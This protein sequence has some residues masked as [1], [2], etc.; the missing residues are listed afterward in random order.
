MSQRT[1]DDAFM[2]AIVESSDDAIVSKDL[3]GIV[4]SWNPAAERIFG[5]TAA[6]MIGQSIRKIIPANRQQEE[7]EVLS[8]LKRAEH[9]KHYETIRRRKDG[10]EIPVSL[11]VSP[12]RDGTGAVVGASKIARDISERVRARAEA[13]QA[14]E[15]EHDLQ[16]RL[17]VLVAASASALAT[18]RLDSVL[19]AALSTAQHLVAADAYAVWRYNPATDTWRAATTSGLS[20]E[21]T[22]EVVHQVP[23]N[24]PL[25]QAMHGP[26]VIHDVEDMPEFGPRRE[27]YLREGLRSGLIVPLTVSGQVSGTLVFYYREPHASSDV[28][29]Q[30]AT[31]LANFVAAAIRSAELYED[32]Q[33][34]EH[35]SAF[36]ARASTI[37][38]TSLDYRTTLE[39]VAQVA[40]PDIAD[41][42]AVD[43]VRDEGRL[44]R[45]AVAHVDP[46]RVALARDLQERYPEDPDSPYGAYEVLRTKA[47]VMMEHIPDELLAT[48]ARSSEHLSLLRQLGLQ[49][50][51]CVPLLSHGS[52][53]GVLT[54]VSAESGRRYTESDLRFA[55]EIAAR[56]S[57]AIE[58]AY[59]YEEA[60]QA[61]LLKDEFL[62]TLSHELRTP[63][64]AVLGYT[65]MLRSGLVP[66]ERES[67]ALG[68]VERNA[69]SLAQL[70]EDVLDISRIIA[71]KIRLNVQAVDL[72]H[73]VQDAVASVAPAAEAKGVRIQVITDP[74]T[75]HVSGDPERLQQVVWNLLSN[76]VKFTP[77]GGC[78]QARLERINSHVE[79]VVSDTGVGIRPEFLPHVFERFR[80]ADS[81]FSREHGGLGLGLAIARHIIEMHGGTI[82]AASGG[83][84]EGATFRA[85]LPIRIA[86]PE[87]HPERERVH[88]T[89]L[90]P[91]QPTIVLAL[92]GVTVL[93]VDDDPDA[94]ALM[95]EILEAAGAFVR[96]AG[97]GA[98]ALTALRDAAPDVLVTD[99]GMPHMDG[100]E[101]IQQVRE[102]EDPALRDV[103]AAALTA[104]A[105]SDDRRRALTAGFQLHLS[106]PVEPGELIAAVLR[107]AD[108]RR[109]G[110]LE[111]SRK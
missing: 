63:L 15:R 76:A 48:N 67:Q 24:S 78:V 34:A 54:L 61:N 52:V 22:A 82:H 77:R 39:R 30:A 41:W 97:S 111:P 11:T 66:A 104:Y 103:P 42:C 85:K 74:Q 62:A 53:L 35:A 96:T 80:Q 38:T 72:A 91:E 13:A 5:Y 20:P 102:I 69:N 56:A 25:R 90:V 79:I 14:R 37:L 58:N 60:R 9:I 73:V 70:V 100:F 105:R 26:L 45:L 31:A 36:L 110:G 106:K 65:R 59:V 8:R 6:E 94:L 98:E 44:D 18:P 47:P 86:H 83:E 71:G 3:D 46:A 43:V 19:P 33:R 81:R 75:P 32:L 16:E 49:S 109:R 101:L 107:L 89:A 12:I 10:T 50:Y 57:L 55:E 64:N 27:A 40:V 29:I 95:R 28:D 68:I 51:M 7:D 23:P 21:F 87:R 1:D 2:A 93:A 92:R 4:T 84:G 17:R 88:P 108:P 99:L